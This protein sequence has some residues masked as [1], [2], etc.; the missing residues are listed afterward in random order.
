MMKSLLFAFFVLSTAA[1]GQMDLI[2]NGNQAFIGSKQFSCSVGKSGIGFKEKEGDGVT[3]IGSFPLRDVFYR[4]DKIS[5][6]KTD[7]D[8][9]AI[10]KDDGWSDDVLDEKN[11][12]TLV[13]I[14][15]P[16]SHEKMWRDDDVY[17]LVIVVGFNDDP[18]VVGKGSAIFIHIQ[19]VID[20][21]V[22][23]THGCV[24][25]DKNDLL[26]ILTLLKKDSKL[27]IQAAS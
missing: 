4:A 7:L 9:H 3:P 13:K 24:A 8:A 26:E 23:P 25:F 16:F 14:P 1:F 12:N 10:L 15:H 5:T 22:T 21:E 20:S 27:I 6:L 11:Y 17:D 2:I 18:V 19:R